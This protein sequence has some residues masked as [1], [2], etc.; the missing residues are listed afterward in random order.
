MVF[1]KTIKLYYRIKKDFRNLGDH[2]LLKGEPHSNIL[3]LLL[4]IV[5]F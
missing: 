5:E 2:K 4:A 1:L 3:K